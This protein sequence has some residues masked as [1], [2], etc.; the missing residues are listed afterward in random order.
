MNSRGT[1]KRELFV[2]IF[3]VLYTILP[4][5]FVIGGIRGA[6]ILALAFV[7][8]W[9]ITKP[10]IKKLNICSS[11]SVCLTIWIL[12]R[13]IIL[14][15][16]SEISR[17]VVFLIGTV[18]LGSI[19]IPWINTKERFL[20]IID[21][22]IATFTVVSVLGILES[23]SGINVFSLLNNSGAILN[24]NNLR[25]GMT[26]IISFTGQTINYCFCCTIMG[27]LTIYRISVEN[28]AAKRRKLKISYFL[29]F[30]NVFLTL[31]RSIILCF[32][33]SQLIL[34][35]KM[36]F[37]KMLKRILLLIVLAV[38]VGFVWSV[39][40]GSD[41][42]FIMQIVYMLLAVFDSSYALKL[43]SNWGSEDKA[44]IGDRFSLYAWVW[45]SVKDHLITGMGERAEFAYTYR[46]TD[47]IYSWMQTKTSIEVNYLSLLYHYGIISMISEVVLYISAMIKGFISS[48]KVKAPWENSLNYNFV[49]SLIILVNL[50]AWFAVGQ[51]AEEALMYFVAFLFLGYHTNYLYN[52]LE[53]IRATVSGRN[54]AKKCTRTSYLKAARL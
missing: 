16:H 52:E 51:G 8:L 17:A 24:Y 10:N 45:V 32:I 20:K 40:T 13:T 46:N 43:S 25:L 44:G 4:S 30:V 5:Y 11:L 18:G 6:N 31:S 28:G 21:L 27:I 34:L 38:I 26:R 7:I 39:V 35:C 12:I 42:N 23:F 41:D 3:I 36:G 37:V 33:V 49:F 22:L 50:V 14:F 53:E 9:Y 47:G 2:N 19:F 48:F 29:L 15:Y 54:T 1:I